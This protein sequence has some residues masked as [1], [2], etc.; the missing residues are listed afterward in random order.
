[1][2]PRFREI[3]RIFKET[4]RKYKELNIEFDIDKL[5]KIE[6]QV[7][8]IEK[9]LFNLSMI[10]KND[11]VN[12][13]EED[14]KQYKERALELI[15]EKA[16]LIN[17]VEK[18]VGEYFINKIIKEV[19][20]GMN[21]S[22]G[23]DIPQS[24]DLINSTDE[25]KIYVGKEFKIDEEFRLGKSKM[26]MGDIIKIYRLQIG[27][28]GLEYS[29]TNLRLEGLDFTAPCSYLLSHLEI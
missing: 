6:E 5:D 20:K 1:M 4:K 26:R 9:E 29:F 25:F 13:S 7:F 11:K 18:P 10:F 19:K 12:I 21:E 14:K 16:R 27:L 15:E 23:L 2:S 3:K 22:M 24:V 17:E 28:F 8:N